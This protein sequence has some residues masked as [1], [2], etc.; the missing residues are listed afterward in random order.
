M[1]VD[2]WVDAPTVALQLRPRSARAQERT[3][4]RTRTRLRHVAFL[5]GFTAVMLVVGAALM[6]TRGGGDPSTVDTILAASSHDRGAGGSG[7]EYG[8]SFSTTTNGTVRGVTFYAPSAKGAEPTAS[9]WSANGVLLATAAHSRATAGGWRQ[10]DFPVPVAV[11]GKVRY[12][13]SFWSP[14]RRPGNASRDPLAASAGVQL[15]GVLLHKGPGF[16]TRTLPSGRQLALPVFQP[17]V[18]PPVQPAPSTTTPSSTTSQ[19]TSPSSSS[20][21]SE[22]SSPPAV[23]GFP[24]ASNTGVPAGTAL[25][26]YAGPCT[27][28][29]AGTVIDAKVV[30]CSLSIRA[31]NVKISRSKIVGSIDVD[32]NAYSATVTDS[33]VD[34]GTYRG[35]ALGYQN[36]TIRRVNAHGG[37][38][39]IACV[40]DCVVEDSYMHGQYL[41]ADSQHLGGYLSNGGHNVVVR[42]NTIECT[43]VDNSAG[44]GCTGDA[45]IFGDF[46]PLVGYTFDHNLFM[47]TPGGY[48][49][50]FGLNPGKT[51]G[52]NPTK[53]VVTNNVFQHGK[54]GKCGYWGPAT[55]FAPSGSGN[56]WSNNVWDNGAK[57]NP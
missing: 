25:A 33:D 28:T 1:D 19:S 4:R 45:Q 47:A 12:V 9:I 53:I 23:T 34:A 55:S 46:E 42:H 50:A 8:V 56:V 40:T 52:S 16:P 35:A 43:P 7:Y 54:A 44:G 6:V 38:T 51:Y 24:S 48:C 29:A 2:H 13:V 27:I 11:T 10:A 18:T 26:T 36:M 32:G 14:D 22:P 31:A 49:T 15:G 57:L 3:R 21:S 30:N 5:G 20:T 37:Q 41:H 17:G 39:S